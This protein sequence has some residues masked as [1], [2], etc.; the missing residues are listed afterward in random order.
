MEAAQALRKDGDMLAAAM[1]LMAR[2]KDVLQRCLIKGVV[3]GTPNADTQV[4]HASTRWAA[5]LAFSRV[6]VF[7]NTSILF[8]FCCLI[9]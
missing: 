1:D 3:L 6:V 4:H 9:I 8:C 7:N 5:G 2:E